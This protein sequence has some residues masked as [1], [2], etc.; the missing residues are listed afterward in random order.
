MKKDTACVHAGTK[1]DEQYPGTSS[2]VYVSTSY[3]YLDSDDRVYPRYF[4]APNQEFIVRKLCTLEGTEDALFFSSGMA[5]ISSV[6]LTFLKKGDHAV[7]QPALYGGTFH[8]V[9][10]E[11]QNFGIEYSFS[12]SVSISALEQKIRSNT[13]LIYIESPSNPLLEITDIQATAELA[14]TKGILTAI[15]STFA[16]PINQN[17]YLLGIDLIIHSGTKYLGGH[18]DLAAGVVATRKDL[19]KQVKSMAFS[20]GGSLNSLDCYLMERSMKTL[21]LR[22][23]KQNENGLKVARFLNEHPGIRKVYYPGL[24]THPGHEIAK[25]QMSGFGGMLSF[26]LVNRDPV[27]FQKSLKLIRPSMSL[28]GVDSIVCSPALT[29]HRHLTS[30]QQA[31]SGITKNVLRFSAG[32]EDS[33][34]IIEDFDQA[35]RGN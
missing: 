34:D 27:L 17:P 21:F 30:E 33:Q 11:L 2:P 1:H 19:A 20:L 15:D 13:K 7:F 32:I 3:A 29:S 22:V 10:S 9:V 23:N 16:S 18:S 24:E 8:M 35:L 31:K 12:D 14:K 4:N 5:A 25:K 28:G 26:E 6:L